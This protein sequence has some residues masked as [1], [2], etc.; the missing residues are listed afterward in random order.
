MQ[1]CHVCSS[2]DSPPNC[3]R[4]GPRLRNPTYG[5]NAFNAFNT[6]SRAAILTSV[7]QRTP[8]ILPWVR[9]C[10]GS[11]SALLCKGWSG[12][13]LSSE[14]AQQGDP[15]EPLF[16]ALGL[17]PV[18]E[19]IPGD[20]QWHAFYL[21]DGSLVGD[22]PTLHR[23][24]AYLIPA[25]SASGLIPNLTKCTLWGPATA[26][27]VASCPPTPRSFKSPSP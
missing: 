13:L 15:L 27:L 18:L 1:V 21:D 2:G 5:F 6:V 17:Q 14:G 4:F 20:F 8:H 12:T 22:I 9:R 23:A 24:L 10:L 26:S 16:F 7:A 11:P 19:G 3:A 25:L